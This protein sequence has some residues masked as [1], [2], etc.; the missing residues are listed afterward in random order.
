MPRC[1][2]CGCVRL[3]KRIDLP[4]A[5]IRSHGLRPSAKAVL[6]LSKR[7][8]PRSCCF[9]SPSFFCC[10]S[11][12]AGTAKI[13]R[14]A[15]LPADPFRLGMRSSSRK[16]TLSCSAL[17]HRAGDLPC[18]G[19]RRQGDRRDGAF[20]DRYGH[21]DHEPPHR[22]HDRAENRHHCPP[23]IRTAMPRPIAR[24]PKSAPAE[25]PGGRCWA[26]PG[27]TRPV[28]HRRLA[29]SAARRKAARAI[30]PSLT[31]SAPF[32]ARAIW[33]IPGPNSPEA[34]NTSGSAASRSVETS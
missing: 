9:C 32:A 33:P 7:H 31:G 3:T 24:C 26:T 18:G 21:A 29:R 4:S 28:R 22:E 6:R 19:R 34:R 17:H 25:R 23:A 8:Q 12:R 5:R 14:A 15:A 1:G 20:R 30:I 2:I 16:T 11:P 13:R 27:K 10:L